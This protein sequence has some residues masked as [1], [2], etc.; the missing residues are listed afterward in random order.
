M[1]KQNPCIN[2]HTLSDAIGRAVAF[3]SKFQLPSGEFKTLLA[4]NSAMS[5][6]VFD[7]SPFATCFV[8][9]SLCHVDRPD[10]RH[11]KE[12]ALD[13]IKSE[14]EFGGVWRYYGRHQ[15]KHYRIPPDLDD[16]AC[17]SFALK[18]NDWPTPSNRW[19]VRANRDSDGRFLTWITPKADTPLSLPVCVVRLLGDIQARWALRQTQRP[20]E[21]SDPRLLLTDQDLV[22]PD[23]FDPVVAANAILYLGESND[24]LPAITW[25]IREVRAE[26]PDFSR[27]YKDPFI[28]YYMVSRAYKHSSPTLIQTRDEI[29]AKI[30]SQARMDGSFG[31]ALTTGLAACALLTFDPESPLLAPAIDAILKFQQPDGSWSIG[32]F[33]SGPT[34]YWGSS[35][36]STAFCLEALARYQALTSGRHTSFAWRARPPAAREE[37]PS[38]R[39]Q[40]AELNFQS[41]MVRWREWW[42]YK[43]PFCFLLFAIGSHEPLTWHIFARLVALVLIVSAVANYG[44]A[45]NE[46]FDRQEDEKSNKPNVAIQFGAVKDRRCCNCFCCAGRDIVLLVC[47]SYWWCPDCVRVGIADLVLHTPSPLEGTEMVGASRRRWCCSCLPSSIFYLDGEL[48]FFLAV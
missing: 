19:I 8:I 6:A 35:E 4:S 33:Y 9:Y 18:S 30:A 25:L 36:L 44:H 40:F 28:L 10:V 47:R 43:I 5:N 13:F 16:T 1:V 23:D 12:S 46:L 37:A 11:M 17:A 32:P 39:V 7:S 24:T 2:Q 27:Y 48:R 38:V 21:V 3:L 20:T 31:A 41:L 42:F 45:I 15:Y 22:P 29:L 26:R 34:E 14:K